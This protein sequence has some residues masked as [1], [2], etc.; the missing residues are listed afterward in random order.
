MTQSKKTRNTKSTQSIQAPNLPDHQELTLFP[1][2]LEKEGR[3][4]D[5]I[6]CEWDVSGQSIESLFFEY[7]LVE[8]ANFA[9]TKFRSIKVKDARIQKCDLSN[10]DWSYGTLERIEFIG[11]RLTGLK[12]NEAKFSDVVMMGCKG[13]LAQFRHATFRDALFE[14]CIFTEADFMGADLT[15]VSF[16]GCDLR[17]ANFTGAKLENADFRGAT[18]DGMIV[19]P[20]DLKGLIIDEDQAFALSS[21]FAE[22]L[23]VVI[24]PS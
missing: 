9:R 18:L 7:F 20:A 12:A 4:S 6:A 3:Y 5:V 23:G 19:R 11:D 10:A 2:E 8:R 24:R 1:I 15:G 21:Y 13:D 16:R 14:E 17:S 22:I